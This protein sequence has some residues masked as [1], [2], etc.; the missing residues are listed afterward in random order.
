MTTFSPEFAKPGIGPAPRS[1]SLARI[2]LGV[3][4]V[5]AP[6]PY[7]SVFAWAW[8]SL[9]ILTLLVLVLWMVGSIRD[10]VL[11]IGFSP[12]YVPCILL[13]LLGWMQLGLHWTLT[14]AATS[15]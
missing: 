15:E 14:P 10:Q 11:R 1:L 5:A 13:L 3:M 7:G 4:L 6:L 9:T 12:L 8:A 2:L